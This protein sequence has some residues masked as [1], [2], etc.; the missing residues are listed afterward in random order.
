MSTLDSVLEYRARLIADVVLG[1]VD[2]RAASARLPDGMDADR[3]ADLPIEN[4]DD[5]A[6]EEE[7]P[8]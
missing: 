8:A 2:A 1:R 6:D 3:S 7:I 5:G 4:E